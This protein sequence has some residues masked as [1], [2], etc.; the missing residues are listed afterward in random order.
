MH[1][2][3]LLALALAASVLLAG[4]SD[5]A[6]PT[7]K[8]PEP[9]TSSSPEPTESQTPEAES[10]ED[11]IRRWV[12]V[13]DEM[14]VTGKTERYRA[15]THSSCKACRTFE[16]AVRDVYAS[17]GSIEFAGTKVD[18]IVRREK[19]PPTFALT[20][21]LPKT[22]IRRGGAADAETLPAGTTTLL[23]ILDGDSGDW[24]VKYY[25]VL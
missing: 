5:K 7:P 19:A 21:T 16:K 6:E 3:R 4:C 23:V 2:R 9:T 10:P 18:R 22:V 11:F 25:G 1:V 17:G 20:K 15:I 13:G 8:M 12:Q 24:S 14:Q